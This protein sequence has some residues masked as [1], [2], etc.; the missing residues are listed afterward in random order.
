[1]DGTEAQS[2]KQ[3]FGTWLNSPELQ[4]LREAWNA[5]EQQQAAEDQAW[6]DSL[7]Y[8]TK[9]QAFRQIC[10]LIYQAEVIDKG[11]YR[12][13]IYDVFGLDYGDGLNHYMALHNLI[14]F[15]LDHQNAVSAGKNEKA[16]KDDKAKCD[17]SKDDQ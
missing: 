12:W 6:W 3:S 14:G 10:K 8:E 16:E 1:M 4:K 17:I 5:F 11:S 13:A 2:D 9:G 7:N 15:A